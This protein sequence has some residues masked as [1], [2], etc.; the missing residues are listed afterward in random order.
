[1]EISGKKILITGGAGFIGSHIV[2]D[3]VSQ[4]A[5][6]T[7][8]DN[9]SSGNEK[10]LEQ[11]KNKIQIVEDDILN[12]KG[13]EKVFKSKFDIVSHQAAQLE[14]FKCLE[15]IMY[16]L[17]TNLIGT[18]NILNLCIKYNVKKIINASSA[19]VYGQ[20]IDVPQTEE[21]PKKPHWPYG[22]SK[23]STEA[24]CSFFSEFYKLP[25]VNLRYCI[26]FGPREWF[27]RV[28]PIFIKRVCN[29]KPPVIFGDGNQIRDFLYVSD[30]VDFHRKVILNNNSDGQVYN[31]S[32]GIGTKINELANLICK[33]SDAD[34]EPIYEDVKA[35]ELSKL[36]EGRKRIPAELKCMHLSNAKAKKELNWEPKISLKDG[37]KKEIKWY[38]ENKELW[39][40]R[41][42]I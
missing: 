3:L 38:L 29:G 19:C 27:G 6:V 23:L 41:Y 18:I 39:E 1:M 32:S 36:V 14:I 17:N 12:V 5:E 34:L 30:L 37:I 33:L 20:A 15:D 16:D 7:V 24:Y 22:A 31:V 9:F 10:Y 28:I 26:I 8:Y 25:I 21:H 11:V 40:S 2:D 13:L 42:K 4:G 35:G